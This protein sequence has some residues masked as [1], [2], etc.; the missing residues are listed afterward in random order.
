MSSSAAEERVL[1]FPWPPTHRVSSGSPTVPLALTTACKH[2]WSSPAGCAA[3]VPGCPW[4]VSLGLSQGGNGTADDLER[5]LRQTVQANLKGRDFFRPGPLMRALECDRPCVL[6][7]DELDKVDDGFEAML[8]EILSA[9]QLSIPEFGT[10]AARSVPFVVLTSN[11]ERRLGAPNYRFEHQKVF[12]PVGIW[13]FKSL[14]IP[15]RSMIS[16]ALLAV[17]LS[18]ST[19]LAQQPQPTSS[20]PK[21]PDDRAMQ[22]SMPGMS[23]NQMSGKGNGMMDLMQQM[24]PKSF[25]QQI[26]HHSSSG[27]SAEPNSTPTPMLMTMKGEWML[28]FHANAFI[29]DTQQSSQRGGDKL[30]STNWFMPMAQ[31]EVGPGQLTVRIMFSLE[32]ATIT[33]ERYPLL[34]QIG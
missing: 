12:E 5:Q 9:W 14:L 20:S 2:P 29:L 31:R 28:M 18:S 23:D 7:I 33:R 11:E 4:D 27:T 32:P 16:R 6:L 21:N 24:H 17:L 19:L 8:L 10:V 22:K 13:R 1:Q 15:C 34:F 26:Q 30:F 25:L 3:S